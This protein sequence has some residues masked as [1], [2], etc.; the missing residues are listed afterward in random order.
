[1]AGL[2]EYILIVGGAGYIGS[3]VNKRL[4]AAGYKTVVF[5]N[6]VYGHR[7]LIRWGNFVLGDLLDKEQLRLCFRR[8]PIAAV[9]HFSAFAYVGESVADPG[10]YY[11]NNVMGTL[12]LLDV[13][14]EFDVRSL[15][16]SSSCATYG[17][18]REIPI[19]EDHPRNPIN[20]Y[21][22][23]K[24]MVEN[25]LEDYDRAYAIRHV[26]MRYFNAAGADPD[27]E[28]GEWHVPE[29]HLLPLVL[30]AAIGRRGSVTIY[31][32]DYETPDGTC[33]RDYIH[34]S[35]LADAHIS[36]LQY[37][38]AGNESRSFNLGNGTGFSVRQVIEAARKVTGRDIRVIEGD[39]RPGDPPVLIAVCDDASRVLGWRPRY[40]A[41][42]TIIDT[43][44]KWHVKMTGEAAHR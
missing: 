3:H 26:N 29:T 4:S 10:K 24:L 38:I 1:M 27:A 36:A 37:L 43:A 12:N 34:V 44:W 13:M 17:I 9:M 30:D 11:V 2:D 42:E 15:I 25:I 33:I 31:G 14:R 6:L 7:E 20:P 8:Y 40:A 23:S 19:P 18:P 35:D 16:F 32:T 39:R 21:G 28:T 22:R 5:D 41:I